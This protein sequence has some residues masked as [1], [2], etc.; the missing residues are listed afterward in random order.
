MKRFYTTIAAVVVTA[1]VADACP[2]LGGR[3]ATRT[4][5]VTT[6]KQTVE[7]KPETKVVERTVLVPQKVKVAETK[8]VP[9]PGPTVTETRTKALLRGRVFGLATCVGCK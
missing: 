3:L 5:T 2:T 1:S 8:L 9:T 7:L 4:K 6:T